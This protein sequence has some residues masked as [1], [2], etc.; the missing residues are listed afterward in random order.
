MDTTRA[1][2]PLLPLD[3]ER[4][5]RGDELLVANLGRWHLTRVAL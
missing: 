5:L 2:E 4:A 1:L 3:H